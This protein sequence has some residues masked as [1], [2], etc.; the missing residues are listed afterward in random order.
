M[1]QQLIVS[2]VDWAWLAGLFEGEGC[3][4]FHSK[5]SVRAMIAM[6]DRDVL[7]RVDRLVPSPSGVRLRRIANPKHS[8]Q[9]V[10]AITA[11]DDVIAFIEGIRPWLLERR[12]K[13]A[14]EAL[15]RLAENR[16]WHSHKTHCRNGHVWAE[17]GVYVTPSGKRHC[18]M[19][20]QESAER[21]RKNSRERYLKN[22]RERER[23]RRRRAKEAS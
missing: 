17:A 13:R 4:N 22:R 15:A 21:Y 11:R 2:E 9:Y 19:C 7:E 18:K 10:W 20:T 23:E 8:A 16:G 1:Q 14:D 3:F 12:G 5:R 6:T